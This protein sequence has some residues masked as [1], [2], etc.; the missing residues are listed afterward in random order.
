MKGRAFL[1]LAVAVALL[2]V[3]CDMA[4]LE[5]TA[6]KT[7]EDYHARGLEYLD[8]GNYDSAIADFTKAINLD[9]DYA[10]AYH[11]R[12]RAYNERGRVYADK[13]DREWWEA[14]YER[15]AVDWADGTIL[16]ANQAIQLNPNDA[17][18][19]CWRGWA[20]SDKKEYGR[21]FADFAYAI[22]LD[23]NHFYTY[24]ARGLANYDREDY[25]NA[26]ADFSQAIRIEPSNI[27]MYY[28]RSE[29]YLC[30]DDYDRAIADYEAILL[31]APDSFFAEYRIKDVQQ[32]KELYN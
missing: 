3:S 1:F 25:D 32:M 24:Y 27:W 19:Y 30:K 22:R 28:F 9:P 4:D 12:G 2:A 21:A 14:D 23:P 26:I 20:Y 7:A 13:G 5:R 18:A 11:S 29:V 31:I 16:L 10:E 15:A 17:D 6:L 8:N